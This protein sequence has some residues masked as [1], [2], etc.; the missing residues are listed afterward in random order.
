MARQLPEW[1][2][3][4]DDTPVPDRVKLRVFLK[5]RGRCPMCT[6]PLQPHHWQ[7]DHIQAL[8]NGGKN[9]EANL[10]PLCN[11][12]CHRIKTGVDVDE[13]ARTYSIRSKHVGAKRKERTI[14]AWRK[15]NGTP[16]RAS[17]QR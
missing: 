1:I 17:R 11:E 14:T 15:F 13:K 4:T 10:Q 8:I 3:D 12:P 7:C 2:G 16:V 5:Y 6:R 9:R